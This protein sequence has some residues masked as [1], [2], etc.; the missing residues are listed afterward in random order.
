[1][2]RENAS[3]Q[4]G[5]T[6]WIRR[7]ASGSRGQCLEWFCVDKKQRRTQAASESAESHD[8]ASDQIGLRFKGPANR[9]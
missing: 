4:S 2:D 6:V 5:S 9:A 8:E 1:M 3:H 7:A